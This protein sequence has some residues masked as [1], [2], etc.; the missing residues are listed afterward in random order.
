[1]AEGETEEA[2]GEEV[3]AERRSEYGSDWERW[4]DDR[5]PFYR[6]CAVLPFDDRSETPAEGERPAVQ[7]TTGITRAALRNLPVALLAVLAVYVPTTIVQYG[8]SGR[9]AVSVPSI[10]IST[11]IV[12]VPGLLVGGLWLYLLYRLFGSRFRGSTVHRS[13]VFFATAIPLAAGTVHAAY[14]AWTNAGTGADPA[15]TV[16]A[17]YFLFVLVAGHLVYDGL[18]LRTENL[19]ANLGSTTI[20]DREIYGAF[21]DGLT[22]TL[23]DTISFGPVELPESVTFAVVVALVPIL[24]PMLI[25]PWSWVGALSYTAYS[26]VT[27]FVVAVLYDVFMLVYVFTELLRS[28]ALSY[29]PFHPDEHG[30]FRDLGRFATRVNAILLVAGGYVAYRFYAEGILNLPDGGLGG[31]LVAVTWLV[32][33]LGPVAAYVFLVLFWLYHSFWRLHRRM[34]EGRRERMEELQRAARAQAGEDADGHTELET[35]VPAWESLQSAPTWPIKRQ[36]LFGIIV[37]D[38]VPVIATFVL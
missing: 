8:R 7:F 26:L 30:G 29:Q 10:G 16:Q 22:E 5:G 14:V 32:L 25:T 21:Y 17:G 11:A 6:S 38:A 37:V 9:L 12:A 34:E 33:Y 2:Q 19:L 35:D 18:A 1:M 15:A 23:G 31:P 3:R 36:S 28:D 24:L 20:V 13:V 4:T 27:L